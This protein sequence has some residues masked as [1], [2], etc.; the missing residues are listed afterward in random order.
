MREIGG[1]LLR[2]QNAQDRIFNVVRVFH[3]NL[4]TASMR[5]GVSI[6]MKHLLAYNQHGAGSVVQHVVFADRRAGVKWK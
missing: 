6:S 2:V 5:A 1:D 3:S 4:R